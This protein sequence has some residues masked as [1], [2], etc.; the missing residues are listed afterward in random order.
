ME[1]LDRLSTI[2]VSRG[3]PEIV[4]PMV[5]KISGRD[6]TAQFQSLRKEL[7]IRVSTRT[8][9]LRRR[10]D[11]LIRQLER[12][13]LQSSTKRASLDFRM[14]K[15]LLQSD[16]PISQEIVSQHSISLCLSV[17]W[18]FNRFVYGPRALAVRSGPETNSHNS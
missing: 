14:I 2:S 10:Y 8:D 6:R 3:F 17:L 12:I 11:V 15:I 18:I 1:S 13:L 16:D 9:I 7:L 4:D 5:R